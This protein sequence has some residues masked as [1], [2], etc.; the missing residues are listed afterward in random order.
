MKTFALLI[1]LSLLTLPALAGDHPM[2]TESGW[3]DLENCA[4]CKNLLTDP[5]LLEHMTWETHRIENGMMYITVV[6]P[7]YQ[8]SYVAANKAMEK[9]GN[10]MMTGAVNPM[11]VKM[12]GSCAEFGQLMMAGVEMENIDGDAA[13]IM[14]ITST[15][16]QMV[17]KLHAY[18][19][20]NNKEMAEFMAASHET[21]HHHHH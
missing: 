7:G 11:Q 19:D 21:E 6:D 17:A 15:D 5:E 9:L 1:A 8:K 3:F 12:C 18:A 16:P 13:D 14:L 4:F 2:A 20:R 10:D